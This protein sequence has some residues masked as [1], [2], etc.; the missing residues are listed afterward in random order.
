M[1]GE[2]FAGIERS[3]EM[4]KQAKEEWKANFTTFSSTLEKKYW[5]RQTDGLFTGRDESWCSGGDEGDCYIL[6]L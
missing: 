1:Q 2:L 5:N 4:M 6:F 3:Q